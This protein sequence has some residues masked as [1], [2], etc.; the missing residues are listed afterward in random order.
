MNSALYIEGHRSEWHWHGLLAPDSC[1]PKI[2]LW[3]AKIKLKVQQCQN[4]PIVG[5]LYRRM[6][7]RQRKGIPWPSFYRSSKAKNPH[8]AQI[9]TI[10]TTSFK[11]KISPFTLFTLRTKT[12]TFHIT[13]HCW[14]IFWYLNILSLHQPHQRLAVVLIKSFEWSHTVGIPDLKNVWFYSWQGTMMI[15][16]C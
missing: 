15:I 3:Y 5:S 7:G 10:F 9:W 11:W 1:A 12:R 2:V 8:T 16:C 13:C 14:Q 4:V 6:V